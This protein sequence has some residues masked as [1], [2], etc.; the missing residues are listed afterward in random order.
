[1][2]LECCRRLVWVERRVEGVVVCVV[3]VCVSEGECRDD[4]FRVREFLRVP[5]PIFSFA[6]NLWRKRIETSKV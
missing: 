6:K 4:W 1:M 3:C 5:Y 2:F